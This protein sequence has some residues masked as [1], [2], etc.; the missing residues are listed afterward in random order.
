MPFSKPVLVEW[1]DDDEHMTVRLAL[2]YLD[3]RNR[4]W[5]VPAGFKTDGASIPRFLWSFIGSPFNGAYRLPAL[6]HDAAYCTPGV[7]R[8][9]ADRMFYDA[10]REE[11]VSFVKAQLMWAGVRVGGAAPYAEAQAAALAGG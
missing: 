2:S 3:P 1:D 7:K 9:E 11:G 6:F 8:A 5:P 10:M 4:V